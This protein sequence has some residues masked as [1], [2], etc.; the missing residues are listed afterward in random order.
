MLNIIEPSPNIIKSIYS[1]LQMYNLTDIIEYI[2]GNS[3]L[4]IWI[5][6]LFQSYGS[7]NLNNHVCCISFC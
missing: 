1:I 6:K 4:N 3:K 5:L 7:R 2:T